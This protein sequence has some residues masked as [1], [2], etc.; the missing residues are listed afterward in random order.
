M[1]AGGI[2]VVRFVYRGWLTLKAQGVAYIKEFRPVSRFMAIKPCWPKLDA[3][4][5]AFVLQQRMKPSW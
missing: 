4:L 5:Q 2:Y 1:L 3:L